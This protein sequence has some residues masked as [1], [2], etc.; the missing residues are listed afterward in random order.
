MSLFILVEHL[1]LVVNKKKSHK[2]LMKLILFL[3]AAAPQLVALN[4]VFFSRGITWKGLSIK[5]IQAL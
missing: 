5:P 4:H 2:K 1:F 3:I